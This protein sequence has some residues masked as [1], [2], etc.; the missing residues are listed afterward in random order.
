[1][2]VKLAAAAMVALALMACR[3][4]PIASVSA[5]APAPAR[6]APSGLDLVALEI[7]SGGRVH[8]FTVEVARTSDEQARGLMFRE[9]LGPD[10]GMIFPF[11]P[12]RPASF[13]MRNTL[14][15]LDILFVRQDGTIARIAANAAPMSEDSITSGGEPVAA[16]LELRGGRAGELGIREGDRVSWPG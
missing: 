10:E 12:P 4:E 2:T 11:Q 13:W 14:I 9:A 15:P 3:A 5:P 8:P 16:V 7:R 6:T 1:M